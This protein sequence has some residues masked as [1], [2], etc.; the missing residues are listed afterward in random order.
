M[1]EPEFLTSDQI[2]AIADRGECP[3]CKESGFLLGPEGGL[4]QNIMCVHCR[5]RF[6]YCPPCYMVPTGY[7]QRLPKAEG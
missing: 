7:A 1:S 3:D 6:N 5:T 4:T 2:A